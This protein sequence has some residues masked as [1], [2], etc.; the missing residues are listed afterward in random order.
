[1]KYLKSLAIL[2]LNRLEGIMNPGGKMNTQENEKNIEN[3][4]QQDS[5]INTSEKKEKSPLQQL[6]DRKRKEAFD[7]SVRSEILNRKINF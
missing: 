5:C 3:K 2:I 7:A 4:P 6:L 1:M